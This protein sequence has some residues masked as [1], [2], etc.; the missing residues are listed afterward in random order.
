MTRKKIAV[1]RRVT[2]QARP[3]EQKDTPV[4]TSVDP[5]YRLIGMDYANGE[6]RTSVA[7]LPAARRTRV[8]VT[9]D[10][11]YGCYE[12]RVRGYMFALSHSISDA[13]ATRA[14]GIHSAVSRWLDDV[15][16]NHDID[17]EYR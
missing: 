14:G 3:P 1:V 8:Y 7:H 6:S 2:I 10:V 17:F 4:A 11:R 5:E 13:D 9:F 15:L 16:P 12:I